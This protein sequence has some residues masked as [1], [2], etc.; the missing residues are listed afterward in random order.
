MKNIWVPVSGAI[1]QQRNVDTI[2]NNVAN[3]NTPGFK[4]DQLVFKEHLTVFS[5]G[6]DQVDLPNKEWSPDDFYHSNGAENAKVKVDGSYTDFSQ[7]QLRPTQNPLDVALSGKG[8]FEVLSPN[9]IRYTRRGT[10]TV[11]SEGKLVTNQ[12]Y[13]VLSRLDPASLQ[14]GGDLAKPA[15][16]SI[17]IGSDARVS[18]TFSGDIFQKGQQIG[19][20]SVVE[21]DDVHALRKEGS[22]TFINNDFK[23]IS[24]KPIQASVRQGFVEESNV[25]AVSEMSSLIQATRH[26]QTIQRAMKAYDNIAQKG[27][28]E[29]AKF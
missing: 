26:F 10:F 9:G 12:G 15:D 5:K 24:T 16:R 2:A 18:V 27:V 6:V 13:P 25:N 4:K 11:S 22:A 21:F 17:S 14:A 7:G 28:N 1:A 23:N 20:L 29:I 8:F 19:K 3:A